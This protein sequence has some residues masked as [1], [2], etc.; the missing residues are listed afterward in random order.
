MRILHGIPEVVEAQ[1]NKMGDT[2]ACTGL[3]YYVVCDHLEV[4]A[5]LI[6]MREIRKAQF[7]QGAMPPGAHRQ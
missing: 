1:L 5:T 3:F 7:M 4:A 6:H 2:Y